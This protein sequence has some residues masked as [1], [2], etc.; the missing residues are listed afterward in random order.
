MH[1]QKKY[2]V[3]HAPFWHD[4]SSITTKNYHIMLAAL[5]ALIA[6]LIQYG[7]PALGVISLS[8]ATA[9]FWELIMNK[10]TKRTPTVG[11]G[12]AALTGLLFAMMLPPTMPWWAV[13]TGTF[14]C[15]IIGKEIFGGLGGN[16]FNPVLV[17]M[18]ILMIA[19]K[20]LFDFDQALINY[21]FEY[22][23]LYPLAALKHFGVS[24][25]ESLSAIDLLSGKQTGGIG[26]TCGFGL[27]LGGVYLIIRGFSRWEI[28]V[29]Y[30]LGICVTAFIFKMADSTAYAGPV[31]HLFSGYTLFGAFFLAT[32]DSS[33]P[34]NFIPMLIYGAAIGIMT[35]LIRNIG[36][37]VD[38]TVFAILL[39]N[40]ANPIIDK[41][42][43]RAMGRTV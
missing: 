11:N 21:D 38:G 30:L 19:W 43:P 36:V 18:A 1:K 23:V 14:V 12:N 26:T 31:I 29:S 39:I 25:I 33:S 35:I 34:V 3:S 13:I 4:G 15:V 20:D 37:Y 9:I 28:T 24:S 10:I 42:R 27:I 2:I 22:F 5:I 40:L 6:G 8:V 17:G 32:E 16:P 41:I 7:A